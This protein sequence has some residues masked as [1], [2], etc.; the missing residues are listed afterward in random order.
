MYGSDHPRWLL[1]QITNIDKITVNELKKGKYMQ[2]RS[3][4]FAKALMQNAIK[5][6]YT[7]APMNDRF[8]TNYIAQGYDLLSKL[9]LLPSAFDISDI[10]LA[11]FAAL[12]YVL[13]GT[14]FIVIY[15]NIINNLGQKKEPKDP[16]TSKDKNNTNNNNNG[17]NYKGYR[18][19]KIFGRRTNKNYF[20]PQYK[21]NGQR[22]TYQR[23]SQDNNRRND[24]AHTECA[25][26]QNGFCIVHQ[27]FC[28]PRAQ[29]NP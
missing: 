1:G 14:S 16:Y 28:A 8:R 22:Q 29:R 18:G 23:Q 9:N 17:S 3:I 20:K 12:K 15:N 19:S 26:T 4:V 5:Y 25:K 10:A 6:I 2:T 24:A 11:I 13:A 7:N 21:N 27:G